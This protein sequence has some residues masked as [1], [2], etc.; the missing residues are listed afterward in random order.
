M[1]TP[2]A[3]HP[4][5]QNDGWV[6]QVQCLQKADTNCSVPVVPKSPTYETQYV[7]HQNTDTPGGY[8]H[9]RHT[10]QITRN[11]T[12]EEGTKRC[13]V[14]Q[15]G[16]SD[17]VEKKKT[18]PHPRNTDSDRAKGHVTLRCIGGVTEP[19]SRLIRTTGVAA[20]A[21]PHTNI[22][23]IL[24]APRGK[25][26]PQDKCGVVY[27]LACHDCEA[28]YIGETERALKQRLKEHQKDSSPVGHHMGYNNHKV[29]SQNIRIIDRDSRWFQTGVREAIQ[30]RS[31]SPTLNRDRATHNLPSVWGQPS[32]YF[33]HR[34]LC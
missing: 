21:K 30:I 8:H 28:S 11:K 20:H 29:D 19:I 25:N 31:R 26:H 33:C 12:I 24:L 4:D 10:R 3:R 27:Q 32:I 15:V 5:Y 9:S 22:R 23:S 16:L 14:L 6:T 17:S 1:E 2:H 7:C 18:I 34:R 13:G